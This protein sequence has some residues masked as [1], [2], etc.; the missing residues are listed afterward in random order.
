MKKN[1]I[2]SISF[3]CVLMILFSFS[4]TA[5]AK[6]PENIQS[7]IQNDIE[8]LDI[9]EN[10]VVSSVVEG[11]EEKENINVFQNAL[12]IDIDEIISSSTNVKKLSNSDYTGSFT[13]DKYDAGLKGYKY[14]IKFDWTTGVESG[15]YV[16]RNIS[17]YQVVTYTNYLVLALTWEE[18]SY[19]VTKASWTYNSG[20]NG[21]RCT[22]NYAFTVRDK[23][24]HNL[25]TIYKDNNKLFSLNSLL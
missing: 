12:N 25:S 17:H 22:A 24:S 14:Q 18:Y 3:F 5:Y 10:Y 4:C 8:S 16:F 9:D 21:I 1:I 23:T 11:F 20:R 15:D 13:S 2:K 19:R 6:E 7:N